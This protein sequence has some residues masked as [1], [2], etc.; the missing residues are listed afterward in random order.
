[1]LST[2][3]PHFSRSLTMV[4]CALNEEELIEEF[5]EKSIRDLSAVCKDWEILLINDGSTDRTSELAH[6][7]ARRYPQI[8]VFDQ[9]VNRGPGVCV[10]IGF[11]NASKDIVFWNTVD[12]FFNTE[13]LTW[14]L[15]HLEEYDCVSGVRSDLKANTPYQKL[16]TVCNRGLIR[17]LFPVKLKAYQSVQFHPRQFFEQIRIE[18]SSSFV[19]AEL[20]IKSH[21]LGYRPKE[22]DVVFHPRTK[23]TA[24][25]GGIR[26]VM[27]SVRDILTLWFR[28]VVLRRPMVDRWKTV[29]NKAA[30]PEV[31]RE[32]QAV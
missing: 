15:P 29:P 21:Y 12:M 1:M 32:R 6:S 16:L 8:R 7:Y 4:V 20:L 22:V 3:H 5:F 23:G 27:R 28:W 19:S 14:V 10:Q 18:G 31:A 30:R 2:G 9:K 13:D 17:L 24:K 25:G 11:R 26:H